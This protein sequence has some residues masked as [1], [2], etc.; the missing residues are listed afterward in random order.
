MK[1]DY[2][3]VLYSLPGMIILVIIESVELA[4]EHRF[5]EGKKSMFSSLFIGIV[6]IAIATTTKGVA[7]LCYALV[8][9]Y[10]LVTMP[11][12]AWW[13]WVICFLSDD[14]SF[15]WFHRCSHQVRFFWASHIVHHSPQTFTLTTAF[16]LPWTSHFTGNFLFWAWMPL[17]GISPSMIITMKAAST[18]YQLW[19]HTEKIKR[20]PK[21]VEAVFNTPSHHRVHHG[22]EVEHLDK[23]HGGTLIIWDR[24][25]GTFCPETYTPVYGLTENIRSNNPFIIEFSE[26][27]SLIRDLKRSRSLR[28]RINFLFNS[29]GWSNDGNSKTTKAL[30]RQRSNINS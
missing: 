22:T 6:A 30:R 14:L 2:S 7:L 11:G 26:W 25:F 17:L 9:R 20:L 3:A 8:Y 1:P 24:L 4:R 18:V 28:D 27:G 5:G 15:Y 23:N 16:R 29:P 21:W 10:R 12:D 13:A 19:L